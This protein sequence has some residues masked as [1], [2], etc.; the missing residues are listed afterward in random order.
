[1][2]AKRH[3]TSYLFTPD[4]KAFMADLQRRQVDYLVLDALEFS[5]TKLYQ[6]PAID[7]NRDRFES[8]FKLEDP[9]TYLFKFLPTAP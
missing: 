9:P 8:I 1:M 2:Y 3:T 7:K 4:D 5:S 6:Y